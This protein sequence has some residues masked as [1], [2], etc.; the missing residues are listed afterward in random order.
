MLENPIIRF[1][2]NLEG[3][4]DFVEM[5]SGFLEKKQ[6]DDLSEDPIGF[7]P[8]ILALSEFDPDLFD[9]DEERKEKFKALFGDN[10]E[11]MIEESDDNDKKSIK[12]KIG[13]E[14]QKRFD[15]AMSRFKKSRTRQENLYHSSLISLI[16]SVECFLASLIHIY[17]DKS[18]NAVDLKDKILS[19]ED[20]NAIGSVEDAR[21]YIIDNKVEGVLRGSFN[22]WM[23]FMKQKMKLSASYVNEHNDELVE[24][25][26]R[27]N[28]LVHNGAIV[29][30]TYIRNRPET[31]G[32]PPNIG[33]LLGVS[34]EY[35]EDK[36]SR[37][38]RCFILIAAELWKKQEPDNNLRGSL[39]IKLA[40]DH[41]ER[42]R[43]EISESLSYFTIGDK[44]L[45][46]S[47]RLIAQINYWQSKKWQGMYESVQA[48]VDD[49]DFSAKE[50]IYLLAKYV[51]QE[52]Y[53]LA[54]DLMPKVIE[55]G[56]LDINDIKKWP[57]FRL[58][59]TERE[60]ELNELI[61]KYDINDKQQ[62]KLSESTA[63][64][65]GVTH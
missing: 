28:L 41:L 21:K 62:P 64:G 16:S 22:D 20:L 31:L 48:E 52:N 7:I 37:F 3:L 24:A 51:L 27:R 13:D 8:M 33:E 9:I 39:L 38:E 10:I 54:L 57:L 29:N 59:R 35:L 36:I 12:L 17:Y 11:V 42:E 61:D 34:P 15:D 14:G 1:N 53:E 5:V 26:Q 55:S 2:E 63:N 44:A 23:V 19:L 30:S 43:W 40:F 65:S 56:K 18:P 60:N 6:A 58:I 32:E 4:R 49:A 47:T 46:E 50:P 25:C 45:P